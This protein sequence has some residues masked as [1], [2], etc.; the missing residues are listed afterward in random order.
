MILGTT[1]HHISGTIAGAV[2]AVSDA[3]DDRRQSSVP[4]ALS[5]LM[6]VRSS[7]VPVFQIAACSD[8]VAGC[9]N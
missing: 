9:T 4:V 8:Y 5:N 3:V 2:T 7:P 6:T 1:G